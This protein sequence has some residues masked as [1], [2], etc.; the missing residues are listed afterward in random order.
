MPRHSIPAPA[1]TQV[2]YRCLD[3]MGY[4]AYRVGDDGSVW[5]RKR[6]P[7]TP[8][9]RMRQSALP[10]NYLTTSLYND[11]GVHRFNTHSLILTAFVGPS[12][13][14]MCC[15]HLDGNPHNNALANLRWGTPQE[16]ADDRRRHGRVPCGDHHPSRTRPECL[17]RGERHGCSK[18]TEDQVRLMRRMHASGGHS[19]QS[20]AIRFGVA[21]YTVWHIITRRSW[22]H[23]P[24]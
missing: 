7:H 22:A 16:N 19:L 11:A 8:W 2:T 14:G 13:A 5:T 6:H 3:F 1:D 12:P 18:L 4:P 15:R 21:H 23:L 24:G 9:R 20:L 10:G 17:A